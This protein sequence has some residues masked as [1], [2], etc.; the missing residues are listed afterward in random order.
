MFSLRSNLTITKYIQFTTTNM[1]TLVN[2]HINLDI[3]MDMV[4]RI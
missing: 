4:E 3:T 1:M 2:M